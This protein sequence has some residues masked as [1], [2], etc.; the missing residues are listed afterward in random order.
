MEKRSS[1]AMPPVHGDL[2]QGAL[3]AAELL[4]GGVE[5]MPSVLCHR[6]L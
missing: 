6:F 5:L 2:Y 3:L 4:E 1:S